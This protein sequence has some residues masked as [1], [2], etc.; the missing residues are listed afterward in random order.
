MGLARH[1]AETRSNRQMLVDMIQHWVRPLVDQRIDFSESLA[2]HQTGRGGPSD[3]YDAMRQRQREVVA[4]QKRPRLVEDA[5]RTRARLP[6]RP[7]FD[8]ARLPASKVNEDING[9]NSKFSSAFE[10]KRKKVNKK[11][12]MLRKARAGSRVTQGVSI[13]GKV[14][15]RIY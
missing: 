5:K 8:F 15:E 7:Y 4:K 14:R 2:N 1:K 13:S 11:L 3:A 10:D 9:G 6:E 12:E